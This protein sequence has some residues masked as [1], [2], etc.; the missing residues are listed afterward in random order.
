MIHDIIFVV[1]ENLAKGA[2]FILDNLIYKSLK[3]AQEF[4]REIVQWHAFMKNIILDKNLVFTWM[5]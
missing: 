1:V 3:Q 5:F 2:Y 4:I